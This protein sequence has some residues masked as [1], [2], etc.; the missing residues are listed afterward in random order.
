M[1]FGRFSIG[2]AARRWG[3]LRGRSGCVGIDRKFAV[4]LNFG[5]AQRDESQGASAG[6][7]L[8]AVAATKG[9]QSANCSVRMTAKSISSSAPA[10]PFIHAR[11][12]VPEESIHRVE[13]DRL[14]ELAAGGHNA[15][16]H[17]L[18]FLAEHPGSSN[19]EVAVGIDIAHQP[20]IS[21]LLACLLRENLV[22][23]RS[24][25]RGKRNAWRLTARG[26]EIAQALQ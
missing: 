8:C 24:E 6:A 7:N 17:A 16:L 22:T 19:R 23:K 20:H 15:V 13:G 12:H 21:R 18:L 10:N 5:R 2:D 11:G 25:G 3:N 1:R 14:L 26:E 4:M 9:S